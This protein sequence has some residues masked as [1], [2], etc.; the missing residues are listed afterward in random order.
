MRQRQNVLITFLPAGV[1]PG[2][3]VD[4]LDKWPNEWCV[5]RASD[6]ARSRQRFW[7]PQDLSVCVSD[8]LGD[9]LKLKLVTIVL[10]I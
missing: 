10:S 1:P 6:V 2:G 7:W 4:L 3:S 8:V 5:V 9:E